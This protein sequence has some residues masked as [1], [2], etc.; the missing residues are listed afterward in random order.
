METCHNHHLL[1]CS[2]HSQ[3]VPLKHTCGHDSVPLTALRLLQP[4]SNTEKAQHMWELLS[5]CWL[6]VL[7]AAFSSEYLLR[8]KPFL[9]AISF[10]VQ[11]VCSRNFFTQCLWPR[12]VRLCCNS[13]KLTYQ[14]IQ[15]TITVPGCQIVKLWWPAPM[16]RSGDQLQKRNEHCKSCH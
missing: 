1:M 10:M 16:N 7:N 6:I 14:R 13:L 8:G 9:E 3:G 15:L 11:S 12:S 5:I 4:V 2:K